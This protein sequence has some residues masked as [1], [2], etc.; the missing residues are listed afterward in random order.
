MTASGAAVT[1][2]AL[3][4]IAVL[5]L[6]ASPLEVGLLVAVQE[7]AWL[8]IGIP[9]GAWVDRWHNKRRALIVLFLIQVVAVSALA[10]LGVTGELELPF[11]LVGAFV[12]SVSGVLI[13]LVSQAILPALVTSGEL[14]DAQ[15]KSGHDAVGGTNRWSC[16]RGCARTVYRRATLAT[17]ASADQSRRSRSHLVHTSEAF[18]SQ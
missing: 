15:L 9:S 13:D 8:L 12:L 4:L 17:Y 5:T 14:I 11:L 18:Y 7:S 10:L 3:P 2:V 16:G 1:T 6:G